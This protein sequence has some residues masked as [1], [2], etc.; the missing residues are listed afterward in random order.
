MS[1]PQGVITPNQIPVTTIVIYLQKGYRSRISNHWAT[2]PA[3][4]VVPPIYKQ[5]KKT[6]CHISFY[7]LTGSLQWQRSDSQK[8]SVAIFTPTPHTNK[9]QISLCNNSSDNKSYWIHRVDVKVSAQVTTVTYM[10]QSQPLLHSLHINL[11]GAPRTLTWQSL[12]LVQ[13][14]LKH[15]KARHY[16]HLLCSS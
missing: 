3:C 7:R 2:I 1:F 14:H 12:D 6:Y 13:C 5:S 10:H 4:S 9:W 11:D 8:I 15:A 16:L